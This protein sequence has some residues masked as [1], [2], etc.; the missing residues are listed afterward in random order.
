MARL[1]STW[2]PPLLW[3]AVIFALSAQHGG[4]HLAPAEVV[5]RKLA[6]VTEYFVLTALLLRALRRSGLTPAV[7][8]ATGVALAYA[9]SDEWHQ[10]FVPGRT[11]TP[12]DV[13]IDGLGIAL[14]AIVVSRTRLLPRTA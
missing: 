11:A 5:L 6:H 9:A 8:A 13:A 3:M 10:S 2:L 7:L 4:G 14:A 12:R 1:A